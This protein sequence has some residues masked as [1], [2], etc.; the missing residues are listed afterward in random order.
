MRLN[1]QGATSFSAS[2]VHL[3]HITTALN[4][5]T[6]FGSKEDVLIFID[7]DGLSFARECN[8][9]IWIQLFLSKELFISYSYENEDETQTKLCLKINHLLDSVNVASRN[10]DDVVEC[11][12]SYKGYGSPFILT[13]EDSLISERVEY[14]TYLSGRFDNSG[15]ELDRNQI[16]FECI[17]KGDILH[18]VIKD[19]K[20][21]G[22]KDCYLYA[23]LDEDGNNMFA[24][25]S[26]SQL[27]FSRIKLPNSR[28]IL[29]K[30]E[31][32]DSDSTT[33]VY[34]KPVVG[35]FD[36]NC[37]DKIRQSTKVASKVL[38]RMDAHGLLSVNILSQTDDVLIA[39]TRNSSGRLPQLPKDYPGIVIEVC[40]LEK[41]SID[42]SAQAEIRLLMEDSE[43]ERS[44][45]IPR[46]SKKR[47][48]IA[49]DN[50][51][52]NLLG[53]PNAKL[54]PP[55]TNPRL[56]NDNVEDAGQSKE[57]SYPPSD[58]PLFF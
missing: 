35:F 22:C 54:N 25:I 8:H 11:T 30:I 21:I 57:T 55:N 48:S 3:E 20:E 7:E 45:K 56:N 2:T 1:D 39:D 23:E 43:Q 18:A 50:P 12:L 9:I 27:G 29:E 26:K 28:S 4:C 42:E 17:V 58:L 41:E 10:A 53:L 31:V 46:R 5:L 40:M 34:G 32:Y 44:K 47:H 49:N 51:A 13:F 6:P 14:S 36:F 16:L 19:F 33:M 15:L 24:L 37:F 38:L 52:D